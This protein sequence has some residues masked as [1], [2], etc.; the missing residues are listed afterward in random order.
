MLEF[1]TAFDGQT[2]ECLLLLVNKHTCVCIP[3]PLHTECSRQESLYGK[4]PLAKIRAAHS[5]NLELLIA[6]T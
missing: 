1:K 6:F 2:W 5:Y 3:L 4:Q